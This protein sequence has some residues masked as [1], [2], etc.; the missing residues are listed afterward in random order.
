VHVRHT[1]V[2][3]GPLSR[4]TNEADGLEISGEFDLIK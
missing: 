4:R 2:A 1:T 3:P